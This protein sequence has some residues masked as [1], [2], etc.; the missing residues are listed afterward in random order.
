M[1]TVLQ[2]DSPALVAE[3]GDPRLTHLDV[4][5]LLR[6]GVSTVHSAYAVPVR[7]QPQ[8]GAAPAPA[9]TRPRV[10]TACAELKL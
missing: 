9:P 2:T 1:A 7:H 4:W 10:H 5:R 3:V 6:L 8:P